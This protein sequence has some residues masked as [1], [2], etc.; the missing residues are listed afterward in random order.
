M[1]TKSPIRLQFCCFHGNPALICEN[2]TCLDH[3]SSLYSYLPTAADM[4]HWIGYAWVL[5]MACQL[6]GAKLLSKPMLE[7]CQ[8]SLR[9][10]LKWN[11]NQN[12]KFSSMK[13]HLKMSSAKWQPFYPWVDEL[14]LY[15]IMS[16]L[17]MW[18]IQPMAH[19]VNRVLATVFIWL[20]SLSAALFEDE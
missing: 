8:L 16:I 4:C 5:I 14:R 3:Y 2:V 11:F 9:N 20:N 6:F 13:M 10:K 12:T 18:D 19:V 1:Y 17:T 15:D 7:Y